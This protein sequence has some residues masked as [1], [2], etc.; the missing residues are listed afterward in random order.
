[1]TMQ[2]FENFVNG[3]G[4]PQQDKH[5]LL[6]MVSQ[7]VEQLG[8]DADEAAIEEAITSGMAR[9]AMRGARRESNRREPSQEDLAYVARMSEQ[10]EAHFKN[11]DLHYDKAELDEDGDQE[12]KLG[13]KGEYCRMR[14]SVLVEARLRTIRINVMLPITCDDTYD[15]LVCRAM[16]KENYPKRFGAGQYDERDGEISYRYSYLCRHEFH[17]DEFDTLLHAVVGSADDYY[18]AV[19]KLCVGRLKKSELEDTLKK[20][21]HMVEELVED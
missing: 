6:V 18:N 4:L 15:Y 16:A 19:N 12:F 1:M 11:S 13:F 17:G 3:T 9:F 14:V 5:D 7:Q 21:D 20:V 10:I 2:E 8:E